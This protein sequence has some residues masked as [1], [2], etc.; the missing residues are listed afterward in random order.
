MRSRSVAM[1]DSDLWRL[2]CVN[3]GREL[4]FW[5]LLSVVGYLI[6]V[7]RNFERD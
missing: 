6:L 5:L 1:F 4:S 3:L 2:A 7:E